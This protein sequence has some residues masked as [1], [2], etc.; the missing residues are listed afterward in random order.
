MAKEN[1]G[2]VTPE[3]HANVIQIPQVSAGEELSIRVDFPTEMSSTG[4][5]VLTQMFTTFSYWTEIS[6][7][8]YN[9]QKTGF[10]L[11]IRNNGTGT[12]DSFF[13]WWFAMLYN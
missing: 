11:L 7:S 8:C 5:A 12:S 1:L 3:Y 4:Y 6:I 10:N 13:L 2:R 9:P